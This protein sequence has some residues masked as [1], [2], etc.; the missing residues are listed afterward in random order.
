[1]VKDPRGFFRNTIGGIKMV[2]IDISMEDL[3]SLIGLDYTLDP[4]EMDDL[5]A[6]TISE[7]DSDPEGPDENGHTKISIEIKTSNR[8]DLWS[9]EGIARIL[10]GRYGETGVPDLAANPS[11][12]EIDVDSKLMEIRPYI[13]ASIVKGLKLDDF[14]IK[15]MIQMQDKLDFSYGR[16]RKKTSIGIY[17]ISMLETPIK[18]GVVDRSFKFQPLQFEEELTVDEIFE[19]HPKGIEYRKILDPHKEVPMLYDKNG[20]VLS[21]PPI[22]NSDDVGRVTE[23]TTDVLVEVTGLTYEATNVAL[24]IVTQALRDRGGIIESVVINYPGEYGIENEIT[25]HTALHEMEIDPKDINTYLG[26]NFS[27]RKMVK[28]LETRRTNANIDGQKILVKAPPWRKDIIH[29]VDI[30]EDIAIAADYN[31]FVPID[32]QVV[33]AGKLHKSTD[34]ENMIRQVLMGLGLVEILNYN[35]TDRE[36]L[37]SKINRDEKWIAKNCVELFNPVSSLRSVLR[38]DLLSGLIRFSSRNTHVEYPHR[39]FETGEICVKGN[40]D[41]ITK[42]YASVLLSGADETFETILSV[43]DSL[44]ILTKMEY[45]LVELDSHYYLPGRAAS[46]IIERS[47]VGHIGEIHPQILNNYRVQV[48][49]VWFEIDLSQISKLNCDEFTSN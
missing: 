49:M 20:L 15:Q 47:T 4:N 26:T 45:S 8:P 2:T 5:L 38:P 32:V 37:S 48:P 14:L 12:F 29:W 34:D 30:S 13:S 11:G 17:N 9:V 6:F 21:M 43:F 3:S 39:I 18:Y 31:E 40:K 41:T 25:P 10:R 28:L 44:C 42:Q 33:T 19:Q 16:K 22:I 1:L 24:S 36:T 7:V 46:I 23:D 35:L 27:K